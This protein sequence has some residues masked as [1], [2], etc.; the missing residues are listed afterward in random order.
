MLL[1]CM[2][3]ARGVRAVCMHGMQPDCM[4]L[5]V[6]SLRKGGSLDLCCTCYTLTARPTHAYYC[7]LTILA[8]CVLTTPYAYAQDG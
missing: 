4:H 5:T 1:T 2:Q 7:I 8:V 6:R 3:R